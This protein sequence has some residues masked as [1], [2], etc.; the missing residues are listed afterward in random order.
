MLAGEDH[1]RALEEPEL[2][3]ARKLA[4]GDHRAA[5][6]DCTDCSP[7]K[8]F[9]PVA[10]WNRRAR[11]DVGDDGASLRLGADQQFLGIVG[12]AEGP[13]FGHCGDRDADRGQTDHAV[14]EGDQFGHL[15]HLDL[16]GHVGAGAAADDQTEKHP[17]QAHRCEFGAH[18]VDE[19]DRGH[20]G[21]AHADHAE[22][23]APDGGGGVRQTFECLDEADRGDEIQ[24]DDEVHVRPGLRCEAVGCCG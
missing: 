11:D 1:R 9:E 18:H 4:E 13:G 3:F 16:G 19:R 12:N 2:V 14:H 10:G 5:E 22:K 6:G 8:E 7:K 21:D 20:R 15:G 23:I 24:Q 17:G